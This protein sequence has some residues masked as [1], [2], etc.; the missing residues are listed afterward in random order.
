[1]FV[2]EFDAWQPGQTSARRAPH[3]PQ[4][5][6]PS[7]FACWHW[8]HCI[9]GRTPL[10]LRVTAY[11]S[12]GGTAGRGS[13]RVYAQSSRAKTHRID[14]KLRLPRGHPL[15]KSQGYRI[16]PGGDGDPSEPAGVRRQA[17]RAVSGGIPIREASAVGRGCGRDGHPS[18]SGH[19]AAPARVAAPDPAG[20]RWPPACVRP[21]GGRR[22]G[23]LAGQWADRRPPASALR[24]R[25]LGPPPAVRR[26]HACPGGRQAG[27]AGQPAHPRPPAGARPHALPRRGATITRPGTVLR[28]EI[29]I[30]TFTEWTDA[31]PGFLEVDL[32]AHCGSST[33]GFYL[34]TLCAVDIA[35]AWIELEAV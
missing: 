10:L 33:E 1:L 15:L 32:V 21:R 20:A 8:G 11:R 31:R 28:H 17:A 25:A 3:S 18:Q 7:G 24:A 27:A 34:C 13:R 2:G 14:S 19:P 6:C 4:N 9:L 26:A 30:R 12:R 22:R 16:H 35:T 5:F 29:P 23:P